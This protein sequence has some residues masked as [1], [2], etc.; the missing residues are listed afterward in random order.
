MPIDAASGSG[1]GPSHVLVG[2]VAGHDAASRPASSSGAA[3]NQPEHTARP[4]ARHGTIG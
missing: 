1:L 2:G 3:L 4:Y